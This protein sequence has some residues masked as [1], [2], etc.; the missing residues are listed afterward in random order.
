MGFW[1][2]GVLGFWGWP[3]E[4]GRPGP[5]RSAARTPLAGRAADDINRPHVQ[6]GEELDQR[7]EVIR[8][9]P[10]GDAL[11][12]EVLVHVGD[13]VH[14]PAALGL[15]RFGDRR[16]GQLAER[17]DEAVGRPQADRQLEALVGNVEVNVEF[18]GR[19][20]GTRRA[21]G[22]RRLAGQGPLKLLG[23]H[24]PFGIKNMFAGLWGIE[25]VRRVGER[26]VR[27]PCFRSPA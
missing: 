17:V 21:Q 1:G 7:D 19:R 22:H 8:V 6:I 23:G 16:A 10:Q 18:F 15:D 27:C 14:H 25:H 20:L 5:F 11:A 24:A 9:A 2:F 3:P 26:I 4:L 13:D 12:V